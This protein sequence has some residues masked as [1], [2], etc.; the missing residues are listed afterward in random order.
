METFAETAVVL[1]P[2]FHEISLKER[3]DDVF[4][5]SSF[6]DHQSCSSVCAQDCG[7]LPRDIVFV[8]ESLSFQRLA[9]DCSSARNARKMITSSSLIYDNIFESYESPL[10]ACKYVASQTCSEQQSIQND[11]EDL[12]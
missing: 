9:A 10:N 6:W 3:S 11:F 7:N 8:R 5:L 12:Q 1:Q 2:D 4:D